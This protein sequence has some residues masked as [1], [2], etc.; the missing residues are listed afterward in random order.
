MWNDRLLRAWLC[1]PRRQS[2]EIGFRGRAAALCGGV[3]AALTLLAVGCG[4]HDA[5]EVAVRP[6]ILLV[7]YDTL[8]AD[9][10]GAYGYPEPVSPH[11]DAL[12][13]RG[14][15]YERAVAASSRTAPSH[16]TIMTS[17]YVRDHS[18]GHRNGSTRLGDEETLARVLSQEGYATAA[19]VSNM[20]LNRRV[21]LDAG[22]EIFDDQ[23]PD[24]E[25][26]RAVYERLA[27]GT[28]D[29]AV[30]WL[31]GVK[32]PFFLWV[33]YNDPHG[34]YTPPRSFQRFTG[35]APPGVPPGAEPLPVLDQ[36]RGWQGIPDYQAL[37]S[38]RLPRQY[39]GLYAGEIRYVDENVGP[40]L[41]GAESAAGRGGLV[42]LL[43]SDHGESLGETGFFFSHGHATTPDL[44]HVPLLL[45][46]PD[47]EAGRASELV[48]HVDVMPTLLDLVGIA[49]PEE[50]AGLA[51]GRY[52]RTG[53]ALPD[54]VVFADVGAEVSAYRA[55]RFERRRLEGD[56]GDTAEGSRTAHRW[57]LDGAWTDA[58]DDPVIQEAIEAYLARET[59][60]H[61]APDFDASE[62]EGLRA[63]GYL[64]PTDSAPESGNPDSDS[65]RDRSQK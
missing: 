54:R 61:W 4:S 39:R 30:G 42:A 16:A 12:A 47:L 31:L 58:G 33:H 15:L 10:L 9:H 22:F 46:A 50:S 27:R 23:L 65:S 62:E 13:E 40:L 36:Q 24:R 63:L 57:P 14:V 17:R 48:H 43:T 19:F 26:T 21:G 29:R 64:E 49:P 37:G 51:L 34:P 1:R 41:E 28:T 35:V 32:P 53:E 20:M 45:L 55:D 44:C 3:A 5:G 2:A 6:S 18:I 11:F 59:P 38:F 56:L 52:W 60:L 8:R 25:Y 7:T